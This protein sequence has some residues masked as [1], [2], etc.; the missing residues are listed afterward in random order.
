M[1]RAC[2]CLGVKGVRWKVKK[3]KFWIVPGVNGL[4]SSGISVFSISLTTLLNMSWEAF[5]RLASQVSFLS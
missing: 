3:R 1:L 2:I 4:L 5:R